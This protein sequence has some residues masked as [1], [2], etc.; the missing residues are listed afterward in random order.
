VGAGDSLEVLEKRK[1]LS[2]TGKFGAVLQIRKQYFKFGSS[3]SNFGAVLQIFKQYFNFWSS[4]S[5]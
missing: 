1:P 2:P 5:N 4:I 3:A